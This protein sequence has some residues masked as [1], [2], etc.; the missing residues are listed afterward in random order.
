M[1]DDARWMRRCVELARNAEGRTA[2]NP[3]VGAVIVHD[4]D[5]IETLLGEG[6]HSKAGEPHAESEALANVIGDTTGATLY[7][8]LEPC[9][10]H[11]RTP[12]CTDS[13]LQAGISRVVVGMVDP[14]PIVQGKGIALLRNAGIEVVVGV[15]ENAC[16][17]LN[18]GYIKAIFQGRPR[19]WLKAAATLDGRISDHKGVSQWITGE[20]ARLH[21]HRMRDRVDAIMIGSGTLHSDDPSLTTRFEGGRDAIP[22]VID[23]NLTISTSAKLLNSSRRALIY[24]A[25]DAPQRDIEAD[26][27]RVNRLGAGLDLTS[28]MR[29]L[30]TRDVHNLMVEGGGLL[31]RSLFEACLV[32]RLLMFVAPKVLVGGAGFIGGDPL[33]LEEG[34]EFTLLSATRLGV[35]VLLDYKVER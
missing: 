2:P 16:R 19:V 15:E 22:V 4:S 6:W 31:N 32:D 9:C 23:T 28:I 29:D 1:N 21:G 25:E 5:G 12:P 24:C 13:I 17:E 18:A 20:E 3:M 34:F 14:N 30:A 35:D 8:S 33:D 10:H 11:G 26:V 27:V 7:V